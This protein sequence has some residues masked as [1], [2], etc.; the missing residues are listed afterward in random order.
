MKTAFWSQVCWYLV[1]AAASPSL[2]AASQAA[3]APGDPAARAAVR[4]ARWRAP[5][6]QGRGE[7]A[8]GSAYPVAAPRVAV[9]AAA[10]VTVAAAAVDVRRAAAV[11]V[12]AASSAVRR[13]GPPRCGGTAR[14]SVALEGVSVGASTWVVRVVTVAPPIAVSVAV[15]S[16]R[17]VVPGTGVAVIAVGVLSGRGSKLAGVVSGRVAISGRVALLPGA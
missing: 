5:S 4:I 3:S 7:P 16:R 15:A 14:V 9:A 12:V 6:F 2:G 1:S 10:A 13:R 17:A 8:V 11:L